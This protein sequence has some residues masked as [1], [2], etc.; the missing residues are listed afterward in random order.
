M[1]CRF[2]FTVDSFW[3]LLGNAEIYSVEYI[4]KVIQKSNRL[5]QKKWEISRIWNESNKTAPSPNETNNPTSRK[6]GV[7][8][9]RCRE[10]NKETG[11][12]PPIYDQGVCGTWSVIYGVIILVLF[13]ASSPSAVLLFSGPPSYRWRAIYLSLRW[14]SVWVGFISS[15]PIWD[16]MV[17]FASQNSFAQLGSAQKRGRDIKRRLACQERGRRVFKQLGTTSGW[18]RWD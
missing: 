4:Y 3:F 13:R 6:H 9:K 14:R 12:S 2:V 1:L 7:R 16:A 5:K 10:G 17:P 8:T 15:G 18:A 11:P